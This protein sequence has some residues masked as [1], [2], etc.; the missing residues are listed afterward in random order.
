MDSIEA[1]AAILATKRRLGLTGGVVVAN[2]IPAEHAL[3]ADAI[4]AAIQG[5]LADASR[6]GIAGKALTPFLL[7]RLAEVTEGRSLKAN[8]ALVKHNAAVGAALAVALAG[9]T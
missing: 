8:I 4:E 7:G 2:P 9:E 1:L 3:P 5:A 6:Q